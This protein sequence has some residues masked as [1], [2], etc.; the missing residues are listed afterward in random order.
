MLLSL[1]IARGVFVSVRRRLRG[2]KDIASSV[3]TYTMFLY[4]TSLCDT[5]S[6]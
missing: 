3:I 5:A 6:L 1:V 2:N 4:D